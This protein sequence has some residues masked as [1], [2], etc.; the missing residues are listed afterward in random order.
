VPKED[1]LE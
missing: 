1:N